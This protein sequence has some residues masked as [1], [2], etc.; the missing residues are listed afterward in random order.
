MARRDCARRYQTEI[1]P[2]LMKELRL[3]ERAR[4]C[5]GSRRSCSTWA[6]ARR[7]R[8]PSSSTRRSRSSTAITGQKPVVTQVARR[9]SRTSSCARTCRSACMVTLRGERMY[10]FLDRLVNVALPRVRDFKGVLRPRLRRARQLL[11]RHPRADHLP[12]DRLRQGRQD[13]GAERHHLHDRADRRRGQG[14]A[15]ARSACRS[16]PE[17]ARMAKTCLMMKASRPPKFK[18]RAVQPLPAL[19]PAARLLPPLPACAASACA[20]SRARGRSPA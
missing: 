10:E 18:V 15:R 14:A 13:Q 12:G 20:I 4:R 6:S 9:R 3:H 17:E 19:R 5:R 11:A 8:T 16:G 1:V 2:A 7:S